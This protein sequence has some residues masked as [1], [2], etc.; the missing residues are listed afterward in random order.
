MTNQRVEENWEAFLYL[1]LWNSEILILLG[2]VSVFRCIRRDCGHSTQQY[3]GFMKCDASGVAGPVFD[4]FLTAVVAC[5][6]TCKEVHFNLS[7]SQ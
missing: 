5:N 7:S 2:A 3:G 6:I 4:D 1:A